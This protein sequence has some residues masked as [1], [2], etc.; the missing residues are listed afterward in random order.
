YGITMAIGLIKEAIDGSF[1]NP[2]GSRSKEDLIADHIGARA[3]F[4]EKK[5]NESL[6]K[7]LGRLIKSESTPTQNSETAATAVFSGDRAAP[8][9]PAVQQT[10][11]FSSEG[12]Q[13][14]GS[15]AARQQLIKRYY[16]ASENGD[17]AAMK[18]ISAELNA[19][20]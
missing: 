10:N 3:V 2:G 20:P 18:A 7:Y 13:I 5:Y 1:L 14:G 19:K 16:E 6:N 8:T 17:S 9:E 15:S 4:G 11:P 12:T